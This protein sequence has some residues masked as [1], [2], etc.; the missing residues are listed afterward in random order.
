MNA[1]KNRC[2]KMKAD[3]HNSHLQGVGNYPNTTTNA[4]TLSQNYVDS[5]KMCD[6]N[7]NP[8]K[9]INM[10][11]MQHDVPV[12]GKDGELHPNLR[13]YEC[14]LWGHKV[15]QCPKA[16]KEKKRKKRRTYRQK[17]KCT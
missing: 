4:L 16:S 15:P 5:N 6:K 1:D 2:T 14:G 17:K 7:P 10:A 11:Q 3:S 12:K 9:R 8:M 13:C